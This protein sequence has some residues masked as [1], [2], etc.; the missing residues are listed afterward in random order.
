M[1][2]LP[3]VVLAIS[4]LLALIFLFRL[5]RVGNVQHTAVNS[6]LPLKDGTGQS[7]LSEHPN[8][9]SSALKSRANKSSSIPSELDVKL[10][11]SGDSAAIPADPSIRSEP[12]GSLASKRRDRS[13]K[14]EKA[15][16]TSP[17]GTFLPKT[18]QEILDEQLATQYD[19][20]FQ[21]TN[22][23]D[24]AE[25]SIMA[26]LS[27]EAARMTELL[28]GPQY[29]GLT[30][31]QRKVLVE[32]SNRDTNLALKGLVSEENMV[33]LD[34]YRAS[35]PQRKIAGDAALA[36]ANN[37]D[38]LSAK[39][40]DDLT[41]ILYQSRALYLVEDREVTPEQYQYLTQNNAK[42]ISAAS[43]ILTSAQLQV[44]QQTLS[45]HLKIRN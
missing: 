25:L 38:E 2:T 44:L 26:V 21:T 34:E 39:T 32:E 40:I 12:H 14:L 31:A 27:K 30:A 29:A 23:S 3:K 33:I 37:G 8:G 5:I 1:K 28:T 10:A 15:A 4:L 43:K 9:V 11:T 18:H 7:T 45:M 35:R 13:R 19:R 42:A 36:C 41:K 24:A 20:Y 6:V 16:A 17:Q 22:L